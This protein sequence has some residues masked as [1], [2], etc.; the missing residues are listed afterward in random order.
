MKLFTKKNLLNNNLK[1]I[2]INKFFFEGWCSFEVIVI[3]ILFLYLYFF[4]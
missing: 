4:N 1:N 2:V 3:L